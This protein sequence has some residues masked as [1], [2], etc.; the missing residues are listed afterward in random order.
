LRG[1]VVILGLGVPTACD[2]DA[3]GPFAPAEPEGP[4]VIRGQ[5][6][7]LSFEAQ[8]L[9]PAWDRLVGRVTLINPTDAPV[10]W[11]FPDTCVVLFRLY[12]LS[13]QRLV[14]DAHSKRCLPFPVDVPLDPGESQTF[15]TNVTF[16]FI[17]GN[18]LPEA[19]YHATLYLRP[20]GREEV[21]I[22]VG[23]PRLFRPDD[24][25]L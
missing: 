18:S 10:A 24:E 2:S 19:R 25:M 8:L 13:D 21:E 3:G 7:E 14:I 4:V 5:I 22:A 9:Q 1:L 20:E 17:L 6:D 15:E 23:R 11:R 12:D 16:F